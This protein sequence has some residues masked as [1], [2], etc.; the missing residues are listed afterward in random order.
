MD[1]KSLML[2]CAMLAGVLLYPLTGHVSFLTPWLIFVMLFI[3][4]CK[5]DFRHIRPGRFQALLIGAQMLLAFAAY[6]IINPWSHTVA[7]GVFIC[8]FIPTATAAPVITSMLGGSI[9]RVATLSLAGNVLMAIIGPP[10]LAA[11]GE[12]HLTFFDSFCRILYKVMP[13]M[14]MP[15]AAAM[16]VRY[17]FP[18][19][20]RA[21]VGRQ[22]VSFYLWGITLCI[23]VGNCVDFVVQTFD[24][25]QIPVIAALMLGALAVC[26][27]QFRIGWAVGS[28]LGD[29]VA[30]GQGL[31]Q[32]N[33]VLA[34]W[35]ALSYLTPIASLAPAAYIIWQNGINSWQLM[36]HRSR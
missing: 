25:T 31:A 33:T 5:L 15:L 35:L 1:R 16:V 4:Y 21:I 10:V 14:L 24:R 7:E 26:L 29:R 27:L 6:F 30:G 20:H 8:A 28:R 32:K 23:I 17:A 36:K 34:V 22:A 9:S 2:P 12:S 19:L 13:L 11:I 18:R 3:T